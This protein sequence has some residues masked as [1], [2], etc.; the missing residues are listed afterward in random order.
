MMVYVANPLYDTVFKYLM[1][2]ERIARTMLS[3]LLQKQV[4]DVKMRRHEYPNI[5]REAISMFRVDFAATIREDDGKEHLILIELQKTWLE[6]E[7]L[8]FRQYLAL[9]YNNKENMRKDTD[10]KYALPTVAVYLLGHRVG[11]INEAIVY[12]RHKVY[13][14]DGNEVALAQPDPFVESL[15]HD[16]IIV[17]IP[18]LRGKVN[19]RLEKVLSVFD[20]SQIHTEDPKVLRIDNNS[21]ADDDD[22]AY[23]VHHLQS[24]AS[25]PDIRNSMNAEDEF[26]KAIEDRDTEIMLKDKL[27]KQKDE[28]LKQKDEDLKQKDEDLKQKDEDLKQKDEDLKQ[29]DE[30]LKQKDTTIRAAIQALHQSGMPAAV[31]AQTMKMAESEIEEILKAGL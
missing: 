9:Q 2:D 6:T 22:M 26:F 3:A 11:D 21:F 20:Q 4:V 15:Q 30:D 31:I 14:Y 25:D 12:A 5:M 13:D 1:E 16:S 10:G 17:Q 27:L 29:K 28:D 18:L 23:I 7:T 19:N 24:A 8:R